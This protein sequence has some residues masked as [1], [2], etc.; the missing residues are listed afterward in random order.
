MDFGVCQDLF[1]VF[2]TLLLEFLFIAIYNTVKLQKKDFVSY[3]H[4]NR[5]KGY[6][7]PE[8]STTINE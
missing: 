6:A 2:L 8:P 4:P 3:Q 1:Y 5:N 7:C